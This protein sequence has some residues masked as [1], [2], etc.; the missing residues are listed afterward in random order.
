[1]RA[2]A[3]RRRPRAPAKAASSLRAQAGRRTPKEKPHA[4]EPSMGHPE[5][6]KQIP[7]TIRRNRDWVRNDRL[8]SQLKM[9]FT[10]SKKFE[11]RSTGLF[12]T[13]TT[14]CS[15]SKSAFCSLVN[16]DGMATRTLT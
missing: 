7:H 6:P 5:K 12:S 14:R 1:M 4:H 16:F 9:S 11:L 10:L 3:L 13:L 2:N 8:M 15:C